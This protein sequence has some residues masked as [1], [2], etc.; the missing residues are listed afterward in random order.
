MRQAC[1]LAGDVRALVIG[2][3]AAVVLSISAHAQSPA[4]TAA[5]QV[6][7]HKAMTTARYEPASF[8][9]LPGWAADDHLAAFQAFVK[10]CLRIATLTQAKSSKFDT[11]SDIARNLIALCNV[12]LAVAPEVRTT[13]AAKAFFERAFDV[14]RVAHAD[15]SGLLTGYYEPVIKG[16]RVASPAFP[17]PIYRRPP[18]LVNLVEESQRGAAGA[19]L[20]HARKTQAGNVPFATRAEIDAGALKGQGL[21]LLYLAD[22]VE[23]FFLQIQGSGQIQLPDGQRI[24][25][26]Y[27][28]KNGHPYTSVG[29]HLIDTGVF[30]ANRMSLQALGNWLRADP[31]RGRT[32]MHQN[33]SYVF[34]RTLTGDAAAAPVGVLD[35]SLTTGRSLAVDAGFHTLGL[36]IYVTSDALTHATPKGGFHRLMIAQDVGS[37][38]KGP[39]R[40]DLYFGSGDEAGKIAGITKHPGRFFVLTPK[41]ATPMAALKPSL[42]DAATRPTGALGPTSA[43][44][45]KAKGPQ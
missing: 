14:K 41:P 13:A 1:G 36:P 22:P 40:G 10:S 19:A 24:R 39:E 42:N 9:D 28:G 30:D 34:F 8:S 12:T 3:A 25:V 21:E 7:Q 35:I 29:R 20:T 11:T 33:K 44:A 45:T 32:A 26:S 16:A 5:K 6:A 17:E 27:D 2:A 37:A 15:P 43:T 31:K 38:I 18:D 23:V 4:N